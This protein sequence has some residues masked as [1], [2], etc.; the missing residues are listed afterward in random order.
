MKGG[1]AAFVS[2]A[3]ALD[4]GDLGLCFT[5]D[6]EGKFSG[7][8]TFLDQGGF[9]GAPPELAVF[10][11]PTDL[12]IIHR[13][14][15]CFEV[16]LQARGRA[17]HAGAP[18]LG[19]DASQLFD[20]LGALKQELQAD[21]PGTDLNVGYFRSGRPDA[22]NVVPDQAE[23]VIDVRPSTTLHDRGI[24][25]LVGRASTLVGERGLTVRHQVNI[26]MKPLEVEPAELEPLLAAVRGLGLEEVYASLDG[27]SEAGEVHYRLGVPCVHFGPGPQSLSHQVDEYVDLD[28]LLNSQ[29]VFES[30][31]SSMQR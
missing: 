27:T 12:R 29:R 11:E 15:A 22:I 7:L 3:L 8:R 25:Y 17:A 5:C 2:A 30:L 1:I 4:P 28:M 24:D 16:A 10:A 19:K 20:C 21:F 26:D 23:A 13:H 18:H 14:R 9:A 6:E 31:I